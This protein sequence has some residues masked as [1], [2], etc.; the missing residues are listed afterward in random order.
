MGKKLAVALAVFLYAAPLFSQDTASK[1]GQVSPKYLDAVCAGSSGLSKKLDK[2]AN[3]ALRLFK[4]Q[5][6]KLQSK[7]AKADS[8]AARAVFAGA[9]QKYKELE[10]KMKGGELKQYIPQV[11]SLATSLK[12]LQANPQFLKEAEVVREKL[13]EAMGKMEA[14]KGQLKKAEDIKQF[15]KERKQYLKEQLSRFGLAKRLKKINKQVYYY[16]AQVN[17]Y[18]AALKDPKKAGKKALELLS[19]NKTFREFWKKNSQLASLFRMPGDPNDPTNAP[20][21]AGLQTRAQVNALIQQQLAAGGPAAQA[22]FQQNLQQ[23]QSQLSQLKDKIMKVGGGGQAGSNA[24]MPEGFKPNN[25]KTKSFLQRLELGTNLQS[26]RSNGLLPVTSDLGLSVG[27]KLND[28]SIIG[29]GASYKLGWG[30]NIQNIRLTHQGLGVRSFIDWKLKGAL[31][32]SGGFEMNYRSEIRNID[33]LKDYSTW[34]RS[35]LIGLSRSVPIKSKFFK[36]TKV[37]LLWDFLSYEQVP[38]GQAVI[39]RFGYNF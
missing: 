2:R 37:M 14:L 11:D 24:E 17:E 5:E 36:K 23:A 29:V 28:K 1:A 6:A 19:A 12:F 20:S 32:I 7:L 22:Q 38:R 18:K 15:L 27:Y 25:Q 4:K 9:E 33:Q 31:W 39:I 30:Q 3:K 35:G 16:S 34:Q 26:Q 13:K 10:Q 21:L 8:A